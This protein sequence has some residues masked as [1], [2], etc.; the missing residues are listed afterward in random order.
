MIH[1]NWTS[2]EILDLHMEMDYIKALGAKAT[3]FLVEP[4]DVKL[5]L[6]IVHSE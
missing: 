1:E 6:Q 5:W 2:K 4:P 3:E